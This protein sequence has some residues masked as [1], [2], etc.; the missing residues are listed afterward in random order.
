[1]AGF[2]ALIGDAFFGIGC[3]AN[4]DLTYDGAAR[5]ASKLPMDRQEEVYYFITQVNTFIRYSK[6]Y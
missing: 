2:L 6:L 4:G 5:W 1:L 3:G